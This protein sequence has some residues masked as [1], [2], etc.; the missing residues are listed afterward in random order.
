[1]KLS[2]NAV[3]VL[4]GLWAAGCD[5]GSDKSDIPE[6]F[7]KLADAIEQERISLG[8]PGIAVAVVERGEVTFAHG[9][10]RK[11]ASKPDPVLPT[12]LFRIGSCTKM[13]TA[14]ATLQAVDQGLV[15]LDDPISKHLPG[16]HLNKTPEAAGKIK[17]RHLLSHTSGLFDYGETN[18][19]AAE[20]TDAA[21][22]QYATGR[23]ADIEY[24]ASPPGAVY[25]YSNPNFT[26]AGLIAE[27][28]RATPY[29]TLMHDRVFAPLGMNRTFFLPSEVLA[30]G[31]Y[32]VGVN[33]QDKNNP[34]CYATDMPEVV[35]P[36][37]YDNP[38]M[39]PA[40]FAWS[41]VMDL[42]QVARFLVHGQADVL[43]TEMWSAMTS[44]QVSTKEVGDIVGYGFGLQVQEGMGGAPT[45]PYRTIKLV[46]HGGDVAGFA[47]DI[48]CIPSL[49]FCMVALANSSSAHLQDSVLVALQTLVDLPATSAVPDVAPKP[50][51]Y[52]LYAGSYDDAFGVGTVTIATDGSKLTISIPSFDANGTPYQ[53]ELKPLNVDNFILTVGGEQ[54]PLTF[55]AD[56][57][58]V[59]RYG[60]SRPYVATRTVP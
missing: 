22:E 11:D 21:L 58:G 48:A 42:A 38:W 24:V 6:R 9:F 30:D 7:R 20:Q 25:A 13:L 39:R 16:F 23:M 35:Q 10:G 27:T 28:V 1:M 26:L 55:I 15:S 8:A 36:D 51:R 56:E 40:G 37:S 34:R 52:P 12:T 44:A 60:R 29:R 2:K 18:A 47:A 14:I 54:R 59:Y 31:D 57:T 45:F 5:D 33:C 53:P 19:P 4:L 32:A 3:F 41:S 43:S 46:E 50:E 17:V 49:D